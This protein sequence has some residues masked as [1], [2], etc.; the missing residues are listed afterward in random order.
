MR[1]EIL[2]ATQDPDKNTGSASGSEQETCK[3]NARG[4]KK[5]C[6]DRNGNVHTYSYD[7]LGRLTSDEV[8][9][10][11]T[12]VDGTMRKLGYTYDAAGRPEKFT[13]YNDGPDADTDFDDVV[14]EVQRAYNGFG[15]RVTGSFGRDKRL[16]G[17][18]VRASTLA[19][20]Q[21]LG[22]LKWV[23]KNMTTKCRCEFFS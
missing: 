16:A 21:T 17:S 8:T 2:A 20:A 15:Q 19:G 1:D 11:G 5:S 14:N 18:F 9:T 23:K 10:L 22:F 12:N 4:E 13:S 7:V 3:V 6:T